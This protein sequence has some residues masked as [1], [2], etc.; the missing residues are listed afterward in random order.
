[1]IRC[2]IGIGTFAA[3]SIVAKV[4]R[5]ECSTTF[6]PR[7]STSS[8]LAAASSSLKSVIDRSLLNGLDPATAEL[9]HRNRPRYKQSMLRLTGIT[10]PL[11]HS[12]EAIARAVIARLR[13]APGDLMS[14]TV[15]R[16]A[17]DARKR[18]AIMLV[19]SLDVEV[20]DEA[21]VLGRCAKDVHV[22]PTPDIEYRFVAHAPASVSE[23][24]LVIGAGP[25]GLFAAL[26]LAQMGFRPII[27]E[28]GKE[29]RER[30]KDTWGLWR[31]SLIWL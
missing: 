19:Y 6:R 28:R 23:R 7:P 27:L 18:S 16:R 25:C 22:R 5:N 29:V 15:F 11:D 17:H 24:P 14:C 8:I 12:P 1:M 10:L 26:L 9:V 13:I 31:G 30:T 2:A 21:G 4:W 20:Q 3:T